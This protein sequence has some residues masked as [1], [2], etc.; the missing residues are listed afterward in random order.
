[1]VEQKIKFPVFDYQGLPILFAL[2]I[3]GGPYIVFSNYKDIEMIKIGILLFSLGAFFMCTFLFHRRYIIRIDFS[4]HIIFG[5]QFTEKFDIKNRKI[6]IS[7]LSQSLKK[8]MR[9]SNNDRGGDVSY[10][11][12][13]FVI[14]ENGKNIIKIEDYDIGEW[15]S[16]PNFIK[17]FAPTWKESLRSTLP[18]L[19]Y[20]SN[21]ISHNQKL[22]SIVPELNPI[23]IDE[24]PVEDI[25]QAEI[26]DGC[27]H[28]YTT[29]LDDAGR[30]EAYVEYSLSKG[31][32][33]HKAREYASHNPEGTVGKHNKLKSST[34]YNMVFDEDGAT[35][36]ETKKKVYRVEYKSWKNLPSNYPSNTEVNWWE[37]K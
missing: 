31:I 4:D 28:G 35:S 6:P 19:F 12:N 24:K 14:K 33:D 17:R 22:M 8:E 23:K 5:Q 37:E 13:M 3:L 32:K 29:D 34:I 9:S 1:M 25:F 21:I 30:L 7:D 36:V 2:L 20:N 27:L 16:A 11:V 15:D 26:K 10:T 18:E